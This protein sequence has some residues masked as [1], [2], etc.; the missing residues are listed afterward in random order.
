MNAAAP[1]ADS[2]SAQRSG[3]LEPP[4]VP[5][6]SFTVIESDRLSQLG[7]TPR[8]AIVAGVR[9]FSVNLVSRISAQEPG[10]TVIHTLVL[11]NVYAGFKRFLNVG[12][13]DGD[14][15]RDIQLGS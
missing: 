1:G 7:M 12:A 3:P 15:T 14:R 6:G 11:A 8:H 4:Q 2:V 10:N 13:G 5:G 9:L